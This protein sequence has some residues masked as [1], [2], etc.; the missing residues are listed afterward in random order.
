VLRRIDTNCQALDESDIDVIGIISGE[1]RRRT[2]M[3]KNVPNKLLQDEFMY[4]LNLLFFG[5][6][7]FL[8]LPIDFKVPLS[9]HTKNHCNLGYAFINIPNA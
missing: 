6:Y 9:Y 1:D 5:V 4:H 3:M 7:D 8:Y 2:L